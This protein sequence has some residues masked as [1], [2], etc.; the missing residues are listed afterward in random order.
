MLVYSFAV[1]TV[2]YSI[3]GLAKVLATIV[4]M[5]AVTVVTKQKLV[6]WI[7]LCLV[8][9]ISTKYS[10]ELVN[11]L[12]IT[13]KKNVLRFKID[14]QTTYMY[15]ENK[16]WEET[17]MFKINLFFM[18][19]RLISFCLDKVDADRKLNEAKEKEDE[20]EDKVV[21]NYN[22]TFLNMILYSTY[23]SFFFDSPLVSFKN[24]YKTFVRIKIKRFI[25]FY[26][27]KNYF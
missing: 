16:T 5:Y 25:F 3:Y 14:F 9:Y 4:F 26:K 19:L 1:I 20:P 6:I 24:F 22:H 23:A 18:Y 13:K 2:V 27:K 15:R 7:S 8:I 11:N 10:S 17:I 12:L 21:L